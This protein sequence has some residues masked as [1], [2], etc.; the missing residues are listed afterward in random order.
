M[1][2]YDFFFRSFILKLY[3]IPIIWYTLHI[4]IVVVVAYYMSNRRW[5]DVGTKKKRTQL[6]SAFFVILRF[7]FQCETELLLVKTRKFW[8]CV[9]LL[10]FRVHHHSFKFKFFA[11]CLRLRVVCK[12]KKNTKS[13]LKIYFFMKKNMK[14]LCLKLLLWKIFCGKNH[15][16]VHMKKIWKE[17]NINLLIFFSKKKT[18]HHQRKNH[19][20][21]ICKSTKNW[22]FE[23][24]SI[25]KKIIIKKYCVK[26]I[27]LCFMFC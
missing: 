9:K 12:N 21:K 26:I 27:N 22:K 24:P 2:D 3:S 13:F 14:V 17:L 16:F 7:C 18:C 15:H 19:Q 4:I 5:V 25:T 11:S 6:K 20:K 8:H 10:P 1:Y 23:N